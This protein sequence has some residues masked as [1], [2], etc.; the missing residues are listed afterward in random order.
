MCRSVLIISWPTVHFTR[1]IWM[2]WSSSKEMLPDV[3]YKAV[4]T[5][6]RIRNMAPNEG[7]YQKYIWI[8]EINL[9]YHLLHNCWQTWNWDEKKRRDRQRNIRE[10]LFSKWCASHIMSLQLHHHQLKLKGIFSVVRSWLMLTQRI[11]TLISQ[12]SFNSFTQ[13]AP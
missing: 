8:P 6:K 11:W 10:I 3:Y 5:C 9:Y 2:T 7:I 1:W 4:Q 12:Q 13:H